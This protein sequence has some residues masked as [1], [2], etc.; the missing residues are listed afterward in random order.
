MFPCFPCLFDSSLL[1]FPLFILLFS[2]VTGLRHGFGLII[3]FIN[4]LQVVTTNNYYTMA[5]LH[6]VQSLHANLFSL[7]ALIFT[8]L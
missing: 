7:S 1:H 3:G 8:G 2:C 4:N 6:N 5:A